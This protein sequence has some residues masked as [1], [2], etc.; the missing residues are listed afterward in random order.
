MSLC[1]IKELIENF[2][3][4]L[5]QQV[6]IFLKIITNNLYILCIRRI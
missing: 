6:N 3:L 5:E 2:F 4:I 1:D